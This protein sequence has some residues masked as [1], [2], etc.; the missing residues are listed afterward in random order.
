MSTRPS[1]H[2][3]LDE[4]TRHYQSVP[5]PAPTAQLA[6]VLESGGITAA[7]STNDTATRARV[8]PLATRRRTPVRRLLVAAC[9][10]I[11]LVG[12]AATAGALPDALQHRIAD[13]ASHLGIDLPDPQHHPATAGDGIDVRSG[14]A[15]SAGDSAGAGSPAGSSPARSSP[16]GSS[17]TSGGGPSGAAAT[18]TPVPTVP[19]APTTTP[20]TLPPLTVPPVT[21]PPLT[22]PPLTLPPVTL[23]QL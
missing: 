6:A 21:L 10:G 7:Q 23:P 13:V 8:V 15:S 16:A 3:I 18:T 14:G 1:D 9:L 2:E 22:L 12:T 5:A 20:I 4:L 11:A 19:T 17:P